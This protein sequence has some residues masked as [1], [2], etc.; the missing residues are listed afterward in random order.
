[1]SNHDIF[2]LIMETNKIFFT[3]LLIALLSKC[4][5]AQPCV[6][7]KYIREDSLNSGSFRAQNN[8]VNTPEN[9]VHSFT[10]NTD[11]VNGDKLSIAAC[12]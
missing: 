5:I 6:S 11:F 12:K 10:F 7:K 2:N 8:Q 4:F 3:L 9:R 1:M